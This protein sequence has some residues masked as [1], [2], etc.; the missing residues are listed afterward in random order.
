MPPPKVSD[1]G[2]FWWDGQRWVPFAVDAV[3]STSTAHE[4]GE[5]VSQGIGKVI[6]FVMLALFGLAIL[7]SMAT[8]VSQY[9]GGPGLLIMLI[10][11][12]GGF[13]LALRRVRKRDQH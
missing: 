10:L 8:N 5:G 1:D 2:R 3:K 4:L 13:S 6:L 9:L 7:A 12:A 11:V